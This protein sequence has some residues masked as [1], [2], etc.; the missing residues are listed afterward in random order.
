VL[1]GSFS[2][3]KNE[4]RL[5]QSKADLI[6]TTDGHRWTRIKKR[7]QI[8]QT[9]AEKIRKNNLRQSVKSADRIFSNP[10]LFVRIRG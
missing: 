5:Q 4:L 8:T 1:H 9:F 10:C 2:A 6:L 7:P 3:R